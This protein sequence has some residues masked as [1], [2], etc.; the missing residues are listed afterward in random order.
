M[1]SKNSMMCSP[2]GLKLRDSDESCINSEIKQELLK[3]INIEKKCNMKNTAKKEICMLGK[4]NIYYLPKRP[5]DWVIKNDNPNLNVNWLS[6]YDIIHT[7]KQYELVRKNFKF[8]GCFSIDFESNKNGKCISEIMCDFD[9][10]VENNKN[11]GIIFNT[12]K[13]YQPGQHWI[14]LYINMINN[15]IYFF[16]S[17][18]R[19]ILIQIQHWIDNKISLRDFKIKSN[20]IKHQ[21][22]NTEC[23]M[24][25]LIFIISMLFED[26]DYVFDLWET[27]R[28]SDDDI[29][30]FRK[31][32]FRNF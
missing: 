8:L 19:G 25:S 2:L 27:Y 21:H 11:Y 15:T 10:I 28:I 29:Y 26:S 17:T 24:Y 16:D 1:S 22:K 14:A 12:A 4:N 23:G 7:M 31:E 3:D 32:M 5:N 13:S 20:K 18:G 30:N 9:N 6:N